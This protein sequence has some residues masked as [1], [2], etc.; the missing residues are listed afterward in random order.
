MDKIILIWLCFDK[1]VEKQTEVECWKVVK[2][3]HQLAQTVTD[4]MMGFIRTTP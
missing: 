1:F 3:L 2:N 4:Q